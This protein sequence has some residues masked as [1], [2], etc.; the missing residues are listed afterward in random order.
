[1]EDVIPESPAEKAGF[2][3]GDILVSVG[4]NFT[5]NIQVYKNLLQAP[6]QKIKVIVNRNNELILLTIKPDS[7]L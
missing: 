5:N 6:N 3:T 4:N 1:M 2:K 7:I